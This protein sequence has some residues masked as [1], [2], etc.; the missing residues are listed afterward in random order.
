ERDLPIT[1]VTM[2]DEIL[3]REV[4]PKQFNATL[5]SIFAAL[6]L[7]LA[8]TGVYGAIS[9][10]VAERTHEA[11]IRMRRGGGGARRGCVAVVCRAGSASRARGC[12]P[13]TGGSSCIDA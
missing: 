12:T 13:R 4:S 3:S 7:V 1:E 10:T 11:R 6:A 2:F 5:L 9:Y 8:A